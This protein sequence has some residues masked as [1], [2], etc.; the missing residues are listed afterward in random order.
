M[1][2]A[3]H[4]A[5][6]HRAHAAVADGQG[7]ARPV[8]AG[9]AYH[10]AGC[11]SCRQPFAPLAGPARRTVTAR[12]ASEKRKTGCRSH[13]LPFMPAFAFMLFTLG[14]TIAIAEAS[15]WQDSPRRGS[16]RMS[17]RFPQQKQ[18]G[19]FGQSALLSW[20]P[21]SGRSCLTID[22][23]TMPARVSRPAKPAEERGGEQPNCTGTNRA[24]VDGSG[25]RPQRRVRRW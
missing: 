20:E 13:S 16:T 3:I 2:S 12:S 5:E 6:E 9:L 25:T 8:L 4:A 10:S 15:V 11:S 21:V 14:Y 19:R 1:R 24:I 18:D 23:Q 22:S 7:L 17:T